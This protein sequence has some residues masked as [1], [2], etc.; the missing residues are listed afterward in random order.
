MKFEKRAYQDQCIKHW[1]KAL[2]DGF[3]PV[4]AVPTGAGKTVILCGLIDR[5]IEQ[6][7]D[8]T[9][10]IISHTQEIILQDYAALLEFFPEFGCGIYCASLHR[11]EHRKITVASINSVY[12]LK[13]FKPDLVLID[14]VHT[15]NHKNTGMYRT[16]LKN[17]PQI[18][19]MSA[20]IFRTGHG[21]IHKGKGALFNNLAYD[22]TSIRNFNTLVKDKYLTKLISKST[23]MEMDSSKVK[24]SA[25][26]YNI[27]SLAT[28]HDKDEITETAIIE[29]IKYGKNYKKWLVFAI[30]TDHASHISECFNK[31]G[32]KA[33]ELHTKMKGNRN[34]V[35]ENFKTGSLRALVSVG[36]VTTGFDAPNVDLIVLLRPTMSSVLH[37]QMVGRG[38][39]VAPGKNHCLVLDF[40]GNTLRLGPINNPIIPKK[41]GESKEGAAPA[42][43]CPKCKA[44]N[45][46]MAKFCE[47]CNHEF[48]FKTKLTANA[49]TEEIVTKG[50]MWKKV[51]KVHYAIHQKPFSP[52]SLK[53]TYVCGLRSFTEWICLNH[54]GYAKQKADNWV[55]HRDPGCGVYSTLNVFNRQKYLKKPKSIRIDTTG[56]YPSIVETKF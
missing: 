6:Y 39:R 16:F 19:G 48:V 14:E 12:K 56:P 44:I 42:K 43:T 7:P 10:L 13:S 46:A 52:D 33:D 5:Y 37:V 21:Y 23:N 26:D 8:R 17:M 15:V 1:Y 4:V 28:V 55:L 27:K 32:I 29:T 45:F 54:H 2:L 36:M 50:S 47:V 51:A 31:H 34:E 35:I 30:D 22:L 24:K 38:L 41:K 20:T 11:K 9:V 49:G 53:V 40:A 18:G 25:G 3:N